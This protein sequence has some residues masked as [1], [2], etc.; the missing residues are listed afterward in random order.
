MY[1]GLRFLN[2]KKIFNYKIFNALLSIYSNK[3]D[4]NINKF[5]FMELDTDKFKVTS[6]VN[7]AIEFLNS[8]K[9]SSIIAYDKENENFIFSADLRVNSEEK[10]FPDFLGYD[11]SIEFFQKRL[12][13]NSLNIFVNIFFSEIKPYYGYIVYN[14]NDTFLS[15]ELS[16]IPTSRRENSKRDK[17]LVN[18]Q[19]KR[20][21][22]GKII[23]QL[24]PINYF[25]KE[26]SGLVNGIKEKLDDNWIIEEEKNYTIIKYSKFVKWK[27]FEKIRDKIKL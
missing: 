24:Y 16:F 10:T 4:I 14:K 9:F 27:K 3:F 11:F 13:Y 18:L 23:P 21:D 15:E 7:K 5:E 12:D 20:N 22:I 8:E 6:N 19:R 2:N 1:Y 25:S 26:M 17:Y